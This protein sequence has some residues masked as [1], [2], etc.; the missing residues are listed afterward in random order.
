[1][2]IR[3][4]AEIE[5]SIV[6]VHRVNVDKLTSIDDADDSDSDEPTAPTTNLLSEATKCEL[7]DKRRELT[8]R[9]EQLIE[10]VVER[11]EAL[12]SARVEQQQLEALA[13][14]GDALA[15]KW[16][17]VERATDHAINSK[18]SVAHIRANQ[19]KLTQVRLELAQI[20]S[21]LD[22]E[23]S[24]SSSSS[25]SSETPVT[26]Q[27]D[28]LKREMNTMLERMDSGE[29]WLA[30]QFD[31][32]EML[33]EM[34]ELID[35]LR[36]KHKHV[37][38]SS[39]RLATSQAAA[40]SGNLE[41]AEM[42]DTSGEMI[43]SCDARLA[44]LEQRLSA[45]HPQR[46][47]EQARLAE[48]REWRD[49]L[50]EAIAERESRLHSHA[51]RVA[52]ERDAHELVAHIGAKQAAFDHAEQAPVGRDVRSCEQMAR[53]HETRVEELS[54]LKH[55]LHELCERGREQLG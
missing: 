19:A 46:E 11:K 39:H 33:A 50:A 24:N 29:R 16:P 12:S 55:R 38:A 31:A 5:R 22:V 23:S 9:L 41:L 17:A 48:C 10:L 1:M 35:S 34:D 51:A 21:Q 13:R 40:G 7:A 26:R 20:D 30:G 4:L 27:R 2:R 47:R 6:Q 53:E 37:R 49:K 32:A 43:A 25:S 36:S 54:A 42:A 45:D 52:F 14:L 18:A 8:A 44:R 28:V 15:D 3:K